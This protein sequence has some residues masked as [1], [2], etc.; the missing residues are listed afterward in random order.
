[1]LQAGRSPVQFPMA[2][3]S[4]QPLT[5]MSTGIFLGVI[6]GRC[7]RLTTLPPSVNRMS[8]NMGAS[9]SRKPKGLHGLYRENFTFTRRNELGWRVLSNKKVHT[10]CFSPYTGTSISK[11]MT[12]LEYETRRSNEKLINYHWVF[13]HPPTQQFLIKIDKY[14]FTLKS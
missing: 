13:L 14:R 6:S 8:E 4:T 5:E 2:L 7:V 12:R 3:G 11:N 9:T 10:I 1:M